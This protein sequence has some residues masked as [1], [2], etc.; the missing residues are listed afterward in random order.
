M[1][2]VLYLGITYLYRFT[3]NI[4]YVAILDIKQPIKDQSIPDVCECLY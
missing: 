3:K 1:Q 2:L 4:P